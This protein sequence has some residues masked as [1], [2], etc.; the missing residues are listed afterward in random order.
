MPLRIPH[1]VLLVHL[2]VELEDVD[3]QEDKQLLNITLRLRQFA[4][5]RLAQAQV[6]PHI[7][8]D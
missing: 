6:I 1:S 8:N 4:D 5:D 2:V 7:L 3:V